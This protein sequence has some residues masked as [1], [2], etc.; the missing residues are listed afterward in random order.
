[1]TLT[2]Y[3]VPYLEDPDSLPEIHRLLQREMQWWNL[4]RL[5]LILYS[6]GEYTLLITDSSV[7]SS[8]LSFQ[9]I[10]IHLSTYSF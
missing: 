1:M 3:M 9:P 7:S 6:R 8:P 10:L 4:G 5:N 2:G